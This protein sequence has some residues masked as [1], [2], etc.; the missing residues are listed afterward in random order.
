MNRIRAL[1][2]LL[3]CL[4]L[5]SARAET[6]PAVVETARVIDAPVERVWWAFTTKEGLEAWMVGRA[7]V[8][9]KPGGRVQT[10]Y[11]KDGK[12]GDESTI[13]HTVA[14]L[15]PEHLL[16]WKPARAPRK[17]PFK[18]AWL[19]TWNVLYFEALPDGKT[20]VVDRMLGFDDAPDSQK[21][22]EFFVH[23]NEAT[24]KELAD[25]FAKKK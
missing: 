2:L 24:M 15:D 8:E 5:E 21:M 20:K 19:R 23:G 3:L 1:A 4:G 13:V 14:A 10:R 7:S 25:Y 11:S 12:L 6:A 16:V 17:F 18:A 9:L 22:R